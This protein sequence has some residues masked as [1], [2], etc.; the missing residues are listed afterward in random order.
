MEGK[1]EKGE[2]PSL[3]HSLLAPPPPPPP[4]S[5]CTIQ[6]APYHRRALLSERLEQASCS[7]LAFVSFLSL[8]KQPT[9]PD[10]TS[11][12]PTKWRLTNERRNY[13]LMTRRY[14]DL[15][16]ASDWFKQISRAARPVRSTTQIWLVT[17]HQYWISALVSPKRGK[18]WWRC[19]MSAWLLRLE[20]Y[21][22]RFNQFWITGVPLG[23][24]PR[25]Q[26]LLFGW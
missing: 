6:L 14:S 15:G 9:F 2:V 5:R 19:E 12:F 13:I 18:Q 23:R 21:R 16:S 7:V 10:A 25:I 26:G 1:I 24:V 20:F 4:F 17:R 3:S 8:R 11:G 22:C